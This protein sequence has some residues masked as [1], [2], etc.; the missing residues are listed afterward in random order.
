MR[1]LE[2]LFSTPEQSEH[3]MLMDAITERLEEQA[4]VKD[5]WF[6]FMAERGTSLEVAYAS[7][8]NQARYGVN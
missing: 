7:W 4:N 5:Q 8:E 1:T 6:D 2:N 3:K